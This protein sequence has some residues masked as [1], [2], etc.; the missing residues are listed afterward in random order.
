METILLIFYIYYIV[1]EYKFFIIYRASYSEQQYLKMKYF[2]F[3]NGM[4]SLE[5]NYFVLINMLKDVF[6]VTRDCS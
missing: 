6:Y 1:N 3:N 5:E 2:V 4:V